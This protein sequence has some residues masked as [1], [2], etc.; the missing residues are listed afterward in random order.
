M[1]PQGPKFIKRW[2]TMEVGTDWSKKGDRCHVCKVRGARDELV[3]QGCTVL[4][5]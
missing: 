1:L 5:R 4:E 3:R 2:I